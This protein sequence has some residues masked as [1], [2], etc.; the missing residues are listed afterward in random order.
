[1]PPKPPMTGEKEDVELT[2]ISSQ[3]T[4][5]SINRDQNMN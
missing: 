1:M 4:G 3:A 5:E 2:Q